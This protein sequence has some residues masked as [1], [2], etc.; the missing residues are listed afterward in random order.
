MSGGELEYAA[1][2]QLMGEL[3]VMDYD[4]PSRSVTVRYNAVLAQ[5]DGRLLM[6]RFEASVPDVMAEPLQVGRALNLAANQ[7]AGEVA[8]WV[9]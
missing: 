3:A 1:T 9:D 8:D 6:R 5:P 7:V 2:T 4:A